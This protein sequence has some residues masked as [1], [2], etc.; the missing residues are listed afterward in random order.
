ME[1]GKISVKSIQSSDR[2]EMLRNLH[3]TLEEVND[4]LKTHGLKARQTVNVNRYYSSISL[5]YDFNLYSETSQA[6]SYDEMLIKG[7]KISDVLE[8]SFDVT[9]GSFVNEHKYE[10]GKS[11]W[12]DMTLEFHFGTSNVMMKTKDNL[13]YAIKGSLYDGRYNDVLYSPLPGSGNCTG[14]R[15]LESIAFLKEFVFDDKESGKYRQFML[16][17]ADEGKIELKKNAANSIIGLTLLDKQ[18]ANTRKLKNVL[19]KAKPDRWTMAGN[20]CGPELHLSNAANRAISDFSNYFKLNRA[21]QSSVKFSISLDGGWNSLLK[22]IPNVMPT[23]AVEVEKLLE[24]NI[25]TF[26]QMFSDI[27]EYGET[28]FSIDEKSRYYGMDIECTFNDKFKNE[29]TDQLI[30]HFETKLNYLKD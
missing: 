17:L 21:N 20:N 6:D 23:V 24:N 4:K 18:L 12:N 7:Y 16:E 19:I 2:V 26:K 10:S 1:V 15:N 22:Y 8:S 11:K 30:K 9:N 27:F 13:L 29:N 28:E 25:A 5:S 14:V 3:K